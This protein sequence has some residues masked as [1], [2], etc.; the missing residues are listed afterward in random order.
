M[1]YVDDFE[2]AVSDLC[3]YLKEDFCVSLS[4]SLALLEFDFGTLSS[5]LHS[6][7]E[8]MHSAFQNMPTCEESIDAWTQSL[9]ALASQL[10]I[11][12]NSISESVPCQIAPKSLPHMLSFD[13]IIQIIMLLIALL[14]LIHSYSPNQELAD[15]RCLLEEN[16]SAIHELMDSSPASDALPDSEEPKYYDC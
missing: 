11:D 16:L 9:I 8:S 15:I 3:Q 12:F 13:R 5:E 14:G 6:L 2:K 10:P 1:T 4:D 7:N